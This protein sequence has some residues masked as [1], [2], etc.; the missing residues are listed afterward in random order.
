MLARLIRQTQ[1]KMTSQQQPASI[2]HRIEHVL[3]GQLKPHHLEVTDTS[4][5]C[6]ASFQVTI[7]SEAFAGKSTLQRH[8]LVNDKLKT[9]IAELHAFSQKCL[10]P[11]Q[12]KAEQS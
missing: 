7:V 3:Q 2:Q 4:G 6:G 12:F 8:R 11:E 1:R 9:E 10:T 5:G